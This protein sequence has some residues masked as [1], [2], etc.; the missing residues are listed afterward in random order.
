MQISW[1]S[2]FAGLLTITL[3]AGLVIIRRFRLN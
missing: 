2:L 1:L 3:G